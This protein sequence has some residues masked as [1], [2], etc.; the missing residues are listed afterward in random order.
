MAQ[1]PSTDVPRALLANE[2]TLLA[3]WRTALAALAVAL[4]AGKIVPGLADVDHGPYAVLGAGYALLGIAIAIYGTVRQ[5]AVEAAIREGR[6]L[7]STPGVFV[8]MSAAAVALG[9]FTFVLVVLD[10]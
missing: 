4:A 7:S 3:W 6:D 9:V 5:R 10:A 2:R 1:R 8:A